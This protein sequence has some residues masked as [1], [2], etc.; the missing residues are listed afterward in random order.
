MSAGVFHSR[1]MALLAGSTSLAGWWAA[2]RERRHH[3]HRSPGRCRT[4]LSI[5]AALPTAA[6]DAADAPRLDP[7]TGRLQQ[8]QIVF[9]HGARTP[10]T[11][12]PYLVLGHQWGRDICGTAYQGGARL[13]L[14]DRQGNAPPMSAV[15]EAQQKCILAGG[16]CHRGELT[17]LGQ[18]QVR[19]IRAV[20]TAGGRRATWRLTK[21]C[22]VWCSSGASTNH[23]THL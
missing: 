20:R 15:D 4:A 7:S 18:R 11:E 12:Q 17:L 8:V 5:A 3:D 22:L 14:V 6:A 13:K 10:L 1:T 19:D 21:H 23:P 9:R 2:S 16:G